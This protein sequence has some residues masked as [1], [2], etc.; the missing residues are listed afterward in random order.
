VLKDLINSGSRFRVQGFSI[1]D[2]GLRILDF[3]FGNLDFGFRI[4]KDESTEP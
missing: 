2:C 1:L 4:A 3:G